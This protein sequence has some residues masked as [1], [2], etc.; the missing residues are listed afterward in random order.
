MSVKFCSLKLG[1]K[2]SFKILTGVD[3]EIKTSSKYIMVAMTSI[4]FFGGIP[5]YK[6]LLLYFARFWDSPKYFSGTEKHFCM[7][8]S[9]LCNAWLTNGPKGNFYPIRNPIWLP[10]CHL[11]YV[12]IL[13]RKSHLNRILIIAFSKTCKWSWMKKDQFIVQY[14]YFK[15]CCY[16]YL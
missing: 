15:L 7:K 16:P 2:I 14:R 1:V 9:P 11:E 12:V 13:N 3:H 5:Q 6:S 8:F 4:L 10:S